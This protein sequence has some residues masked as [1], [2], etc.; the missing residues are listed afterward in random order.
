MLK[1]NRMSFRL[2]AKHAA[3]LVLLLTV[4]S[5]VVSGFHHHSN[6]QSQIV[7]Q[8]NC[9]ESGDTNQSGGSPAGN[10]DSSCVSCQLQRTFASEV[11]TPSIL[12]TILAEPI[13]EPVLAPLP[14]RKRP[15]I[16]LSNRA[17]PA[18]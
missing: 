14:T 18:V 8:G 7:E 13:K 1:R 5:V 3:P 11:R 9:I 15:T 12:A 17:P 4:H 6:L 10:G 16:V 2:L